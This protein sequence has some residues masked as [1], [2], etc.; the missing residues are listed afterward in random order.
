MDKKRVNPEEPLEAYGINSIMI[1]QLNQG[2]AEAIAEGNPDELSKT[3]FYEYPTLKEL[4]KYLVTDYTKECM[5]WTGL[6]KREAP[7]HS[8]K[9]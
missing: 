4:S 5:S 9:K 3:L 1:T 6:D 7:L 2:L 8:L